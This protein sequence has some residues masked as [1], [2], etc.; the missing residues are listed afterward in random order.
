VSH[1]DGDGRDHREA[2]VSP[3]AADCPPTLDR[4]QYDERMNLPRACLGGACR[5]HLMASEGGPGGFGVYTPARAD[6]AAGP[7]L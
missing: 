5:P 3:V 2:W 7:H 6:A 4:T 1:L